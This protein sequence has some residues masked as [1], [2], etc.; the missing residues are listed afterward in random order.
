MKYEGLIFEIL[1]ADEKRIFIVKVI[2]LDPPEEG[3]E[4]E[5]EHESHT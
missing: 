3:V 4:E 5:E 1:N 2:K